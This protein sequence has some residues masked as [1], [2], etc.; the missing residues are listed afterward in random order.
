MIRGLAVSGPRRLGLPR[1]TLR[2]HAPRRNAERTPY[3]PN[4]VEREADEV[5]VC[6]VG[7][8][9][10]GLSAAIRLKQLEREKGNGK[11]L[12]VVVLEKGPEVGMCFHS[13]YRV[14]PRTHCDRDSLLCKTFTDHQGS[15]ILSGAVIEPR[16]LDELLPDWSLRDGHPLTQPARNST[17]RW[18]TSKRSFPMPHPPQMSNRGNYIVSLS[19]VASWLGSIAEEEYGVEIYP[20]FA[21]A[22]LILSGDGSTVR[23]VTTNDVGVDRFGHQKESF[24]PGMDFRAKVTLLAEGA[25]GSLTKTAVKQFNLRK[26]SDPQTYGI[27]I[28]EVWRVDPSKYQPGQVVHTMGYPLDYRTYGGG[29]IYHMADGLVS[30]GLVIGLDYAN[31]YLSPYG[32]FQVSHFAPFASHRL[33]ELPLLRK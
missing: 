10:A 24:E 17:M 31:P 30:L 13:L 25:H 18:L 15:H 20:G 2:T 9:P 16:A 33:P 28:K 23:G 27:G 7:A 3:D 4:T 22:R 29:W 1:R 11:E 21:G 19:R 6:I 32:E 12:R 8:G 5:D 14:L 26:D